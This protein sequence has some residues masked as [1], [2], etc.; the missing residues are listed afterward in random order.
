MTERTRASWPVYALGAL[1]AGAIVVAIL[2]VG[3]ASGSSSTVT[4]TATA[5]RSTSGGDE[6]ALFGKG[7]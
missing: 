7:G 2:V 5:G 3:P 1:S 6:P 4:R